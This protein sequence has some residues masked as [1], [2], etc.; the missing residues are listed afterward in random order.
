MF[1]LAKTQLPES[2]K[3]RLPPS[4]RCERERKKEFK[5]DLFSGFNHLVHKLV[6]VSEPKPKP[7]P[8]LVGGAKFDRATSCSVGRPPSMPMPGGLFLF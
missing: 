2:G 3:L 6:F 7:E 5:E 1:Y 4:F 8:K